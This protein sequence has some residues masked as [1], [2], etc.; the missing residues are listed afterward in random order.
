MMEDVWAYLELLKGAERFGEE[1]IEHRW[2]D[3]SQDNL[4]DCAAPCEKSSDSEN[5]RKECS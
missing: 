3:Q 2:K 5:D 4:N 1:D